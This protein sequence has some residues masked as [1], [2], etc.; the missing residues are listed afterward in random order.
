MGKRHSRSPS[1]KLSQRLAVVVLSSNR[2]LSH[3]LGATRM[4]QSQIAGTNDR[5]N[6]CWSNSNFGYDTQVN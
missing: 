4:T 1:G 3:R 6:I 5:I 2:K